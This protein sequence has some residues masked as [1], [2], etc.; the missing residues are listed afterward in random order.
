MLFHKYV[1]LRGIQ[2]FKGQKV[3]TIPLFYLAFLDWAGG[4]GENKKYHIL[5]KKNY[6]I[7]C[8]IKFFLLFHD[9]KLLS[10]IYF[11]G[12][13]F[14]EEGERVKGKEDIQYMLTKAA[15]YTFGIQTCQDGFI[16]CSKSI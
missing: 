5:K 15:C 6:K 16:K 1:L 3:K 4:A 14:S 8:E 2:T 12:Q 9:K 11:F 10:L 7:I 13:P